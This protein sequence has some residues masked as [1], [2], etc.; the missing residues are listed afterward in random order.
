M[1][2]K[3]NLLAI[4]NCGF[5][6][7][8]GL[9]FINATFFNSSTAFLFSFGEQ[10]RY[11]V[12]VTVIFCFLA[13]IVSFLKERF[14]Y[15]DDFLREKHIFVVYGVMLVVFVLQITYAFLI[16]SSFEHDVE[17]IIW[18]AQV[19]RPDEFVWIEYFSLYPNNFLI[20]FFFRLIHWVLALFSIESQFLHALTIVNIIF[21][22][23]AIILVFHAVK[24]AFD[25]FK[26]YIAWIFMLLLV[27]FSP[28]IIVPYSDTLSMPIVAGIVFLY[29]KLRN[30]NKRHKIVYALSM[31]AVAQIGY[32]IKPSSVIPLIAI[33]LIQLI[34]D[35]KVIRANPKPKRTRSKKAR[36]EYNI[37]YLSTYTL[38]AMIIVGTL[39]NSFIHSQN[40]IPFIEGVAFP[41]EHWIKMGM[42]RQVVG[43]RFSYGAYNA[44]DFF[45]T[46]SFSSTQE[47]RRA[48]REVIRERLSDFGIV[49]YGHFLVNKLRWIT[50]D[51]TFHWGEFAQGNFEDITS[52]Q[53]RFRNL[54]FPQGDGYAYFAHFMQGIWLFILFWYFVYV[55]R[56]K[57]SSDDFMNVCMCAIIGLFMFMLLTEGRSRYLINHL[58]LFAITSAYCFS[59]IS[60]SVKGVLKNR[61]VKDV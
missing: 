41:A 58:P 31:G 25:V 60:D 6:I 39:F 34:V 19:N 28:W 4:L 49:G 20:L 2:L 18:N 11:F 50:N 59:S 22:N 33:I 13:F 40:T 43:D 36:T 16:H 8:A 61:T 56:K 14:K 48:D 51:G 23:A 26:G 7:L 15:I 30:A 3:I 57:D 55:F 38:L 53:S 12:L 45:F 46:A 24:V 29:V 44:D 9:L 32:F 47:M 17:L 5:S 10:V 1:R 54:V 21:V 37:K 35:L 42:Q 52:M 27:A